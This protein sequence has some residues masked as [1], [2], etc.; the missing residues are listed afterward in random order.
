[1]PHS[2]KAQSLLSQ[3]RKS[4]DICSRNCNHCL[5]NGDPQSDTIMISIDKVIVNPN[6]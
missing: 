1:M 2:H 3:N 5:E 6:L 4:S